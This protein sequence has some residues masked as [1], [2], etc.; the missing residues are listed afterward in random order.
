MEASTARPPDPEIVYHY[1]SQK[2]LLGIIQQKVLWVSSIRHLNDA[3]EASF[4]VELMREQLKPLPEDDPSLWNPFYER[5]STYFE[6]VQDADSFVG[7]FS[8]ER[9]QLGQWRAYTGGG[10]GFSIGFNFKMLKD[11]ASVQKFE[12][13][14]CVYT[15]KEHGAFIASLIERARQALR[16]K[17]VDQAVMICA[18]GLVMVA[19]RL[20]HPSFAE[21][22]EWRLFAYVGK[23]SRPMK[24]RQGRSML[25]PYGEFKLA[26]A[27]GKMPTVE[28][29]V[30]PTP[31]AQLSIESVARLLSASGMDVPI[32]NSSVPFRN[33]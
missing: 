4:A 29:V 1:T 24:F 23:S 16:Q 27:D 10:V 5:V 7:S 25:I 12:F 9:D 2:G 21:E 14:Q 19:P 11:L 6:T 30:G 15:S 13:Q 22:K 28:I 8:Q 20:K 33:W 3:A 31:H 18:G 32:T 17:D 26:N